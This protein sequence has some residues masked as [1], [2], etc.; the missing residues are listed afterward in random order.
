MKWRRNQKVEMFIEWKWGNQRTPRKPS[1][2]LTLSTTNTRL[3]APGF[4][5]GT[6]SQRISD[7]AAEKA[8]FF[9]HITSHTSR[10]SVN[11]FFSL[12]SLLVVLSKRRNIS[13]SL[14]WCSLSVARCSRRCS[15][16]QTHSNGSTSW[17][18]C[19]KNYETWNST[20]LHFRQAEP[21]FFSL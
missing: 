8:F 19:Y 11:L 18:R 7:S 9:L 13:N 5:L 15:K 21:L 1:K 6:A 10:I 16:E 4:Q 20:S 2:F 17:T 3:P 12:R 14:N